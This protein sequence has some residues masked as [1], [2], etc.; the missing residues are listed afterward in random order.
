MSI[1]YDVLHV[2]ININ[3]FRYHDLSLLFYIY[4]Q[5][6]IKS[7]LLNITLRNENDI[8]LVF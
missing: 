8:S 3:I 1:F 7:Y 2:L 5:H 6:Q 4:T